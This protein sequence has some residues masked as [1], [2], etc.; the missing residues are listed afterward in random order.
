MA[1]TDIERMDETMDKRTPIVGSISLLA[2]VLST[3]VSLLGGTISAS[4]S[5]TGS[6]QNEVI[7]NGFLT[8]DGVASGTLDDWSVVFDTHN[9]I[10]LATLQNYGT[11][12]MIFADGDTAF[13][14]LYEDDVNVSL[15]TFSGPFTQLLTLTGGTGQF[16]NVSGSL[17]GGG[18]IYPTYFTTSGTGELSAPGLVATPEPGSCGLLLIGLLTA[19]V[20]LKRGSRR[21]NVD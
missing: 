2:L 19:A 7:A 5:F 4:Y 17:N 11:F 21:R 16:T 10:N 12:T 20:G 13:G 15:A 14:N 9:D 18:F 1:S 8:A 6:A 3:T